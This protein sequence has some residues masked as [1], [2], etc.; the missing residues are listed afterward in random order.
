M[1]VKRVHRDS[2]CRCVLVH[3]RIRLHRDQHNAEIRVLYKRLRTSP[4]GGAA[5]IHPAAVGRVRWLS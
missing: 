3:A 5:T 2:A 4:R 1:A